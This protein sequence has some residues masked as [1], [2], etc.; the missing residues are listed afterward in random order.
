ME[1]LLKK[2]S[3]RPEQVK[4]VVV[5]S[6]TQEAV[7][8]DNRVMPDL[9]LQHMIAVML[10]D[11]TASFRSAHDQKRMQDPTILRERAKV[12]LV[13][14]EGLDRLLPKRVAIVEVTLTDG[15]HLTERVEAVRGT[16]ENPMTQDEIVAKSRDLIAPTLGSATCAALIDRVLKLENVKSIRELRPLLQKA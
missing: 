1:A 10:V 3:F 8:V 15:S 12:E 9:C 2:Y 6:A 14:D 5:R 4:K 16:A 11:G 13:P 7:I